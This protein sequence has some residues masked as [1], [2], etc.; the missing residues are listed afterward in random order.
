MI[1]MMAQP[2]LN[3]L[4][5]EVV[6]NPEID[7]NFL[8][9]Y[10][11]ALYDFLYNLFHCSS[12][13]DSCQPES[14]DLNPK[15]ILLLSSSGGAGHI[16]A[17]KAISENIEQDH[18]YL[19]QPKIDEKQNLLE[20]FVIMLC[21]FADTINIILKRT[22]LPELV[23]KEKL[24]SECERLRNDC[25]NPRTY[26]DVLLDMTLYGVLSCAFWNTAQQIDATETLKKLI[27]LQPK[28]E[29][30]LHPQIKKSVKDLLENAWRERTPI[31]EIKST[32]P[33][34]LK[35]ICEAIIEFRNE[36]PNYPEISLEQYLTDI[37]S[38]GCQHFYKALDSIRDINPEFV[39]IHTIAETKLKDKYGDFDICD[40]THAENPIIRHGFKDFNANC[41]NEPISIGEH[42]IENSESIA[43]IMLGSA[44]S[45]SSIDYARILSEN[46]DY[47][48]IFVFTSGKPDVS[49]G[50]NNLGQSK[51]ISLGFQ[52]DKVTGQLMARSNLSIIRG[53]GLSVLEQLSLLSKM[54]EASLL[55]KKIYIHH[56]K[57]DSQAEL[58]SGISWEDGNVDFLIESMKGKVDI[59]KTSPTRILDQINP[60]DFR[61][62]SNETDSFLKN[63]Y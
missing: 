7:T 56:Q 23:D 31:K 43:V 38:E 60:E 6:T 35:A 11:H 26:F 59:Y 4:S 5:P 16:S 15:H 48:K 20:K 42:K 49:A 33:M 55:K 32:Q 52:D 27:N 36:N 18:I 1:R 10:W 50:L 17:I 14:I 9:K 21:S 28:A 54:D 61:E 44:A 63:N 41:M 51:I 46:G 37:P 19:P 24:K 3:T 30:D 2:I 45:M 40:H 57:D 58:S 25:K 13:K 12:S 47:H 34:C 39:T 22:S 8:L 53:G 29:E 62:A